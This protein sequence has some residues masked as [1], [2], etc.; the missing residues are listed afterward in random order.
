MRLIQS[1]NN[2]DAILQAYRACISGTESSPRGQK[3]RN[4]A[5]MVI[6][7]DAAVPVLTNFLHRKMNLNYCKR[8][9]LWYLGADAKDES[10][11]EHAKLWEKIQQPDGSFF[12]NYG[13]YIFAPQGDGPSQ[14]E[15]VVKQLRDDPDTRRACMVL[16]QPKHLFPENKDVVCTYAINFSIANDTLDMTVHMRSNDVV[17]GFTNDA[18]CFQQVFEFVY[19]LVSTKHPGLRRGRYVHIADSMHVYEHHFSMLH[20]ILNEPRLALDIR[21]PKPTPQEVVDLFKTR[22]QGGSGAY[23]DWLKA[24]D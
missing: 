9:W 7:L 10:I 18:F 14:F 17:Y 21:V 20:K 3:V 19:Q 8:E 4:V 15:Y 1:T 5:N 12:S 2:H 24:I 6:V 23:V 16:L 22:G 13:Q 11:K